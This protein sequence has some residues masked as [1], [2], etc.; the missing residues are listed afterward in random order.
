M[1]KKSGPKPPDPR[2]TARATTGTNIATA[3]ANQALQ[4]GDRSGPGGSVTQTQ[5]GTQTYTDPY[6]GES[7]E[8]P[9]YNSEQAFSPQQQAALGQAQAGLQGNY[10][11]TSVDGLLGGGFSGGFYRAPY[12]PRGG[13]LGG[14]STGSSPRPGGISTGSSPRPGGMSVPSR[15][16]GRPSGGIGASLGPG[17]G[18]SGGVGAQFQNN[19]GPAGR[20]S[21]DIGGPGSI[22]AGQLTNN[23]S[24]ITGTAQ[25]DR[26]EAALRQRTAPDRAEANKRREIELARRGVSSF[27]KQTGGEGAIASGA[28]LRQ[29]QQENDQ[30]LAITA[31]GGQE[32]SLQDSLRQSAFG[33]DATTFGLN[34][35]SKQSAFGLNEQSRQNAFGRDAATF[36]LNEGA[37]QASFGRDLSTFGANQQANQQAFGQRATAAGLQDQFANTGLQRE[38]AMNNQGINSLNAALSGASVPG[39][40]GGQIPTTD[41]GGIINQDYQNKAGQHQQQQN[42]RNQWLGGLFGLGSA[43]LA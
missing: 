35:Q 15:K 11:Q 4:S 7:Y 5:S 25:R 41:V 20:F 39:G 27:S 17:S 34:E 18:F 14:I 36:G 43:F 8:I 42:Q 33:R 1:G 21:S 28:R 3:V 6:T 29:Y 23:Y 31:A 16:S 38:L 19:A 2:D 9:I 37:T 32:Q 26:V 22:S 12:S 13:S 24:G 40:I 10:G 30:S